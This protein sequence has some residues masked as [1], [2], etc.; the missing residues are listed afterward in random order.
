MEQALNPKKIFE[1]LQLKDQS[2]FTNE[3]LIEFALSNQ[4]D[5]T[6][7]FEIP[8]MAAT[9]TNWQLSYSKYSGKQLLEI[10]SKAKQ[11]WPVAVAIINTGNLTENEMLY[12]LLNDEHL[13]FCVTEA[14]AIALRKGMLAVQEMSEVRIADELF[15]IA[16]KITDDYEIKALGEQK[17][18]H[19]E[20]CDFFKKA[21]SELVEWE[22]ISTDEMLKIISRSNFHTKAVELAVTQRKFSAGT[23]ISIL[24]LGKLSYNHNHALQAMIKTAV[25]SREQVEKVLEASGHHWPVVS[26]GV[27]TKLFSIDEMMVLWDK[28]NKDQ[29]VAC[30]IA[31]TG[32]ATDDH[33][34]TLAGSNTGLL[35][36]L[37][38]I[39]VI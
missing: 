12:L 26:R 19:R 39:E 36:E 33:K 35:R 32:F 15:R 16:E 25:L 6:D 28:S 4:F 8:M 11:K 17:F 34:K 27:E 5:D 21:I 29:G 13:P 37:M 30:S 2:K 20:V 3:E 10:Y 22:K 1:L 24:F 23:L 9:Q 38:E 31:K 18:R 14:V 7:F